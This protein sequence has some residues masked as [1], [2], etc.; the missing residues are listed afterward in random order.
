MTNLKITLKGA[1]ISNNL[2]MC[3]MANKLE[4]SVDTY[5]KIERNPGSATVTVAKR[6]SEIL[7]I[8]YD[9]IFFG[10]TLV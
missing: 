1:R 8:G 2:T 10:A 9:Y 5:R 6:I 3:E 4:I 7:G